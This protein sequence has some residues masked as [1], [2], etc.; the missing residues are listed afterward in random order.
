MSN[1]DSVETRMEC[2]DCERPLRV[3]DGESFHSVTDMTD[4]NYRIRWYC[5]ECWQ[6]YCKDE[7][8]E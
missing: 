5:D 3:K 4:N 8:D 6:A 2:H 7:G 1:L